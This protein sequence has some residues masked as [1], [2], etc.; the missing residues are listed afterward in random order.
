MRVRKLIREQKTLGTDTNWQTRD[1]QPRYAP[2]FTRTLPIRGG[3][4]WRSGKATGD[5]GNFVL[6]AKC[7]PA[8][9]NWQAILIFVG[10]DGTASA[11]TRFEH[12]GSHPGLHA[13]AHCERS[14]VEPGSTSLDDLVRAPKAEQG[15]YH[16]RR[17]S[18][19]PDT[20]WVAAKRFF[21]IQESIGSLL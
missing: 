1:L 2:L 9:D 21:R 6:L 7:N 12:H 18:W 4:Q 15:R 19:T 5:T 10:D 14:G 17:N 13:H 3:W 8:Y 20:F 11:V 16:R